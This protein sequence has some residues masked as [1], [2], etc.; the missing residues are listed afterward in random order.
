MAT[1][2][3]ADAQGA[4]VLP[5]DLSSAPPSS[6]LTNQ[7]LDNFNNLSRPRQLML[8]AGV[9]ATFALVIVM[10]MWAQE[11]SMRILYNNLDSRDAAEVVQALQQAQ[12]PYQL[13]EH[14]GAIKVA[15]EQLHAARL[16]LAGQGLPR[17]Q[18]EGYELLDK[19]VGFGTSQFMESTRY[20]RSLEGELARTISSLAAVDA[21]RVHLAMPRQSVFVRDSRKP[22]ASVFLQ[23]R[24]GR[25][26]DKPQVDAIVH[27]VASSIPNMSSQDVTVVDERGTLLS[28]D[29][30][31]SLSGLTAKQFEYT[32]KVEA[33]MS[34]R[35]LAILEPV[36][37]D[38]R[39]KAQVSAEIDFTV[40]EAT[41][42][43]YNPDLPALRS[44]QTVDEERL[45]N[46]SIAGIP[47]AL[48][49]QPP[50]DA[51]APEALGDGENGGTGTPSQRRNQSTRN[52]ELDRTI[53]H[54]RQQPGQIARLSVAVAVDDKKVV[55][56]DTGESQQVPLTEDEMARITTL[57]RDAVGYDLARGDSLNVVN[58]PFVEREAITFEEPPFYDQEWFWSLVRQGVAALVVLFLLMFILRP[59][60]SNLIAKPEDEELTEI[61]GELGLDDG[62]SDD[63]VTLTG[64]AEL[65]L[66]SPGTSYDNKLEYLRGIIADDPRRV[67]QVVKNWVAEE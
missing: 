10:V 35:I 42:E 32:R 44:E 15:G 14:T 48:T 56:A 24:G 20:Q 5:N 47:G 37:G 16:Q 4:A 61:D 39:V 33:L 62:L 55:N 52:F 66:P 59:L 67:A 13:D 7:A 2:I 53:S 58:V 1:D 63:K 38:E 25:T 19:E 43:R 8:L 64:E 11:P 9:A 34:K 31:D 46:T 29:D 26:L 6:P 28:E 22:S 40:T 23:L 30:P 17:G 27:M 50:T 45:G 60:I 21:A 36:L 51:I 41:A 49:N 54:T 57:V 18:S 12:I 65:Q 3:T